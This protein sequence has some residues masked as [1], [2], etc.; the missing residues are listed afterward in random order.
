M[1]EPYVIRCFS[2]VSEGKG[3]E[4]ECKRKEIE[5]KISLESEKKHPER[6]QQILSQ[7][8]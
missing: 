6:L 4:L 3:S 5:Q 1:S 2:N 8:G 7:H